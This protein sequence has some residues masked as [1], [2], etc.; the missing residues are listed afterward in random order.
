MVEVG[1]PSIY[2]DIA[3][4][5]LAVLSILRSLSILICAQSMLRCALYSKT[6]HWKRNLTSLVLPKEI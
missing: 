1:A 6:E 5:F 4:M 2:I 3:V